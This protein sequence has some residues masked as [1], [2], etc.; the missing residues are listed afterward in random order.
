MWRGFLNICLKSDH[1]ILF[2]TIKQLTKS[3]IEKVENLFG[4]ERYLWF[5]NFMICGDIL[6]SLL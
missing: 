5:K 6:F 2:S 3:F 4:V 1:L